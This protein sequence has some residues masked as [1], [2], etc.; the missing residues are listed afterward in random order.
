MHLNVL[1]DNKMKPMS[2]PRFNVSKY[3]ETVGG[4]LKQS[5]LFCMSVQALV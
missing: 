4:S 1:H 2:W 5:L 3:F